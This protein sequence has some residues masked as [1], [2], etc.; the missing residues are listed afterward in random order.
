MKKLLICVMLVL[1][2]GCVVGYFIQPIRTANPLAGSVTELVLPVVAYA[3][4]DTVS[5]PKPKPPPIF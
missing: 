4:S 2:V 1:M 5:S 3:D